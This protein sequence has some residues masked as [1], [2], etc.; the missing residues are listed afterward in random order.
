MLFYVRTVVFEFVEQE[1]NFIF[2]SLESF[3]Q[4][5]LKV[6]RRERVLEPE[7]YALKSHREQQ[8]LRLRK[9]VHPVIVDQIP[10]LGNILC[11]Y[12]TCWIN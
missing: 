8:L 5:L 10:V 11:A 7:R 9:Y 4:T 12:R 6:V 3:E 1:P 2:L